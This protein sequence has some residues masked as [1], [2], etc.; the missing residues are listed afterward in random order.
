MQK[1]LFHSSALALSLSTPQTIADP[2][3]T[4]WNLLGTLLLESLTRARTMRLLS[5]SF[6]DMQNGGWGPI[7]ISCVHLDFVVCGMY[8]G[9]LFVSMRLSPRAW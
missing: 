5:S 8:L 1:K 6:R 9:L 2:L 7:V 3:E 4:W